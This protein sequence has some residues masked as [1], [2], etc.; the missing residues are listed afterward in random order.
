MMVKD[1]KEIKKQPEAENKPQIKKGT[2]TACS[3]GCKPP[4]R[5]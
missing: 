4:P 2:D 1:I 3:C 5:K